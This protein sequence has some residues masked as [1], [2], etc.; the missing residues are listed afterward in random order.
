MD[1]RMEKSSYPS[2]LMCVGGWFV[3]L[4]GWLVIGVLN[5]Q[6]PTT[7]IYNSQEEKIPRLSADEA[8]LGTRAPT[9]F[10]IQIA[11]EDP[12]V[13]QPI[14][15]SWDRKGRL[16]IAENYTYAESQKGFD[17]SLKDR[18]IILEDGDGDGVFDKRKVFW[19]EGLKLT[20]IEVVNDGVW[21]LAPPHLLFL[22]DRDGDD[23]IDRE[24]EVVLSGFNG[25]MRHNVANGLRLGPDGWLY[26]RHG[27][28]GVSHVSRER[29]VIEGNLGFAAPFAGAT[30]PE[31]SETIPVHCGI[32][33]F[34][35]TRNVFEVVCEGTTNP[36]G[37]DW[38]AHGNLFF[39]NTVIGHLWHAIPNG[40]MQRMYGEDRDPY[41]FELLPQIADHVHWDDK[42]EDWR[43]TRKG[44]PSDLTDRAG[45][46]HAHSGMMIY[47]G[48]QWPEEY[49]QNVFT[50]NLHGRR[51]NRDR[52]ES[53]GSGFVARHAKDM[54]FWDD[55]WFRGIELSAAPDGSVYVLDWSDIGEC[56][57]NDG[58]HRTSGRVYRVAYAG[59]GRVVSSP[60][61][62]DPDALAG[63]KPLK[64][65]NHRNAWYFQKLIALLSDGAPSPQSMLTSGSTRNVSIRSPSSWMLNAEDERQLK[66]VVF[67]GGS[68]YNVPPQVDEL[69]LRIRCLYALHANGRLNEETI[70]NLV[71]SNPPAELMV[72][73]LRLGADMSDKL[74]VDSHWSE[75]PFY[76]ELI[77]HID[78]VGITQTSPLLRLYAASLLPK[79]V[80]KDWRLVERLIRSEDL[81]DDRD[82]PLVLWYG[83]KDRVAKDP[84]SS[85]KLVSK[86]RIPKL[87]E[88]I[89]RRL[90]LLQSEDPRGID[91]VVSEA[92]RSK[93]PS[94]V[95]TVIDALW[96][97]FE[98]RTNIPSPKGW[99]PLFASA[100]TH[101]QIQ[102]QAKAKILFSVFG[103][104]SNPAELLAIAK[105]ESFQESV[106]RGATRWLGT[107]QGEGR[108]SLWD[109]L[110]DPIL[111]RYSVNALAREATL[112]E[113][114]RWIS[115]YP[116]APK[117][118]QS[119]I[120]ALL[121][122]KSEWM[123]L[124]L[125]AL[126]TKTIPMDAIDAI[127]WRQVNSLGDWDLHQRAKKLKPEY[128]MLE[129]SKEEEIGELEKLLSDTN[130]AHGDASRGRALWNLHCSNCHKLFGEGGSIGP[131]LTG[132]QR[133]NLR[134]W[135]ENI[136]APSAQVASHFRVEIVRL[137]DGTVLTGVPQKESFEA[138][139]IQT[140]KE[141]IRLEKKTITE[142]KASSQ[143]L[144]PDR[145][146][147]PLD[148]RGKIDLFRYLMSAGQ[149]PASR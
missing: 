8:L 143:S 69:T 135:L 77:E 16:W 129:R 72:A 139:E 58:V 27:I 137:E 126:E 114:Q 53:H 96:N 78:N 24:P 21:A 73:A 36:W 11:A 94:D 118:T 95:E 68:I 5:G 120:I 91:W 7:E 92:A 144:M 102:T 35:P 85:A 52:L 74:R 130:L 122:S 45:G 97:A 20:S 148:E 61:S 105:N 25:D 57:E 70:T 100:Q 4:L 47:Q 142:R 104:K 64:F 38:D 13:Q 133:S 128:F 39:I 51:V 32:W 65:L 86:C 60:G 138:L 123:R 80:S 9:G 84:L 81:A 17:T 31:R 88:F 55:P 33:R 113:A 40:H 141:L 140:A 29:T 34:H 83:I 127:T 75:V 18:I 136:V 116:T 112:E 124:L 56:H 59:E 54:V 26:G 50:L 42:R 125:D 121:A 145:L 90:A 71:R 132:A 117:D 106:R 134:Y 76:Y 14:G 101:P 15:M 110:D 98:G 87:S 147:V 49:R 37:M 109:L 30:Q 99:A 48:D 146:L 10:T 2:R 6:S 66:Q 108:S 12:M 19:E 62:F 93:K 149:V 107:N 3:L 41:V 46:G 67:Q 22:H 119:A 131:E 82:F 44:P 28:L 115:K 103:G 43:E 1:L 89:V 23:R 63:P 111:G 79:L